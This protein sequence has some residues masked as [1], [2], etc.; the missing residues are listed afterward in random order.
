[1]KP[2]CFL[3]LGGDFSPL[4]YAITCTCSQYSI[5]S[6]YF[7]GLYEQNVGGHTE[8]YVP[9]ENRNMTVFYVFLC[10]GFNPSSN[11]EH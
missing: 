8:G 7:A 10:V 2:F 3:I 4:I 5:K 1:M 9:S 11:F 6:Y